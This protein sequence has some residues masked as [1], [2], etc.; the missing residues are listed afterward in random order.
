MTK[1]A[2][3]ADDLSD[4]AKEHNPGHAPSDQP[5]LPA[6][7]CRRHSH[8]HRCAEDPTEVSKRHGESNRLW[9]AHPQKKPEN[10]TCEPEQ[11]ETQEAQQ[12]HVL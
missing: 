6:Q 8:Q 2:V 3:D 11:P 10:Q 1:A 7:N 12:H 5:S 4:T 9:S